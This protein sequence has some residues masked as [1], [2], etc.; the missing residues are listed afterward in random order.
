LLGFAV[1]QFRWPPSVFWAATPHE[2]TAAIETLNGLSERTAFADFKR[3]IEGGR[4]LE[5]PRFH[6]STGS[7]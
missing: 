1:A 6:P 5:G 3:G 4:G 7:G 2:V